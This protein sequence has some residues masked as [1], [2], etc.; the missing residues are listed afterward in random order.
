MKKITLPTILIVC[1]FVQNVLAQQIPSQFWGINHWMPKKYLNNI[2]NPNGDVDKPYVQQLIKDDGCNV[3]RIGGDGYDVF[4]TAIGLDTLTND[5]LLA[6]RK[7]ININPNAKFLVQVPYKCGTFTPD[8]AFKLVANISAAFGGQVY[9]TIGNEWDRYRKP[10]N[11]K[12]F[13]SEIANAIKSFAIE[14]KFANPSI[15]I[16]AP[17]LSFYTA[18][19]SLNKKIMNQLI[20]G[21]D[22]ITGLITGSSHPSLNGTAYYVDVID[23]HTYGGGSGNLGNATNSATYNSKRNGLINY[24]GVTGS[25]YSTELDSLIARLNMVNPSRLSSKLTFAITEMNVCYFN[26]PAPMLGN[27]YTNTTEGLS[28]RSFFAGQY[29]ADIMSTTLQKG[30]GNTKVEFVMPWSVHEAGGDGDSLDLSM[31]KGAANVIVPTPVSSYYHYQLMSQ[32]F[33]GKYYAS[34]SNN[35]APNI[36]TFASVEDSAGVYVMILNRDSINYEFNIDLKNNAPSGRPLLLGYSIPSSILPLDSAWTFNDTI[37]GNSTVL[38]LYNCHGRKLWK[39]VYSL[40][41][42]IADGTPHFKQIGNTD[43]DPQMA[44]CNNTGIGGHISSNTT[45]SNTTVYVKSNILITGSTKL[46]FDNAIVVVSPGVS[47]KGNP[48]SS[49]EIKNGTVM[50]G[51]EGKSWAGI[52]LKG[53]HQA[54]EKLLV[55]NSYIYNAVNA[56]STDKIPD[57]II[58]GSILANG[59][60]GI[61]LKRSKGFSITGNIIAGFVNGI[62][63]DNSLANYPS[64]IKENTFLQLNTGITFN[65]DDHN[66]LDVACNI[67]NYTN[68]GIYSRGTTLKQQGDSLTSAGNVFYKMAS[69]PSDYIDHIGSLTKY[70]FGPT[71]AVAF[72]LPTVMNIPKVQALGDQFCPATTAAAFTCR[73]LVGIEEHSTQ[74]GSFLIYPNPSNGAFTIQ[75]SDLPKGKWN[76]IVYDV[77][78]RII[79]TKK[80]DPSSESETLQIN[81]R[82]LYFVCIQ[83]GNDRITQKV[84]VE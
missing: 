67:F 27:K 83:S 43:V 37:K 8:S 30:T 1:F 60:T 80:I 16:V 56:L 53:N 23:F 19:D 5:Y 46:T 47:I 82:G 20:G 76:L 22:D 72:A 3:Y 55:E 71:Q 32:H 57:I 65:N 26:Q 4:G 24:A 2:F 29:F 51:C 59:N 81:A 14:M 38:L 6:I 73:Q 17:A 9:Y 45:Y 18:T 40:Q 35:K 15:K 66:M 48:N 61:N 33:F 50:F 21:A 77:M 58:K 12:Y 68:K 25:G 36:K 69:L 64:L 63:T 41:D 44:G 31:T 84:I 10:G 62:K 49:I 39:K 42:A 78:G 34:T 70:Y 52:E 74:N 79:S 13:S 75:Y 28:A 11:K 54:G 7:V